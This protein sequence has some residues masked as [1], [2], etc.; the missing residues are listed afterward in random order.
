MIKVDNK[1]PEQ[2]QCFSCSVSSI[3]FEQVNASW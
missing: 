1:N 3:E 2:R